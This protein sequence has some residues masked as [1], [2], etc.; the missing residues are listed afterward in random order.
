VRAE[1]KVPS[2][3]ILMRHHAW[4]TW[5][6]IAIDHEDEARRT[7]VLKPA[8]EYRPGLVAITAT[9]FALDAFYGVAREL[10]PDPGVKGARG[11]VVAERLKRGVAGGPKAHTWPQR[12][13]ALFKTRQRLCTSERRRCRP[14]CTTP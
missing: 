13:E 7:R 5:A 12:I 8:E 6:E 1:T 4:I 10:I 9:A 14:S 2:P 3:S 11:V